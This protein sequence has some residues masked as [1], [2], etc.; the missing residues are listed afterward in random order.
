MIRTRFCTIK[1]VLDEGKTRNDGAIF[2]LI[3]TQGS[4]SILS[5]MCLSV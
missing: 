1:A 2:D 4:S 3:H 5:C